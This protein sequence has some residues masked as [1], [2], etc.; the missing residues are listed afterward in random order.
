MQQLVVDNMKLVP[1]VLA[2]YFGSEYAEDEDL[3]QIGYEGLC[4]AAC[5]FD[6]SNGIQFSTYAANVIA[7]AFRRW[8]NT[9]YGKNRKEPRDMISL[10]LEAFVDDDDHTEII[11]TIA[12]RRENTEREAIQNVIYEQASG[13]CPLY[14][15]MVQSY[16]TPKDMAEKVGVSRQRI[17]ERLNKE[18]RK[19]RVKFGVRD[20]ID[21]PA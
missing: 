15:D 14:A 6:E 11:A 13:Y 21:E 10:N 16:L 18:I 9:T 7:N 12:D 1:F 8:W 19:A 20:Y 4:R 17:H 3:C 5:M 2:K